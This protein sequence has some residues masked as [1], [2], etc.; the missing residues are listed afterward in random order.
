MNDESPKRIGMISATEG[1][2]GL[3]KPR[4]PADVEFKL[5]LM[6]FIDEGVRQRYDTIRV[7]AR[8]A[9]VGRELLSRIRSGDHKR[10]SI[11]T[12][13]SIA[14]RLGID[15]RIRVERP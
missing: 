11:A 10:C 1:T 5:V 14:D 15:I 6:S 4:I 2:E 7:A 12:L 9:G 8:V 3:P 13:F